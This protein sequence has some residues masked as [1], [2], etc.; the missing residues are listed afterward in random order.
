MVAVVAVALPVTLPTRLWGIYARR[1]YE[2]EQRAG[3]TVHDQRA[4]E[5]A[6][7]VD[8]M[9]RLAA[10]ADRWWTVFVLSPTRLAECLIDES[11]PRYAQ[12]REP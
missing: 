6:V 5:D 11:P 1:V 4:F 2:R 7:A 9:R 3:R 10:L 8:G 12:R